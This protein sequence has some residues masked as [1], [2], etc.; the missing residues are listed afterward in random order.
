MNITASLGKIKESLQNNNLC[1]LPTDTILGLFSSTHHSAVEKIFTAK[2]RP[3]SKPLAIFIP[4]IEEIGKYGI[5]SEKSKTFAQ[6]NLPGAYTLL[7][8]ATDFAKQ[9][10]SPLLISNDGKIGIRIP[11][12]DDI[13]SITQQVIICGTSVNVSGEEFS[14][15]TN[16]PQEI[17]N[18]V[19]FLLQEDKTQAKMVNTPSQ[20]IDFSNGTPVVIRQ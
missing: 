19:A 15:Y 9:N 20:I 1:I 7:L 14:N 11:K 8:Q 18:C 12:N 16:I 2:Q 10:L 6:S 4:T 17:A 13:I 5:E 3:H